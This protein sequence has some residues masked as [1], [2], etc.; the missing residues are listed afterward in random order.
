M[1]LRKDESSRRRIDWRY[2]GLSGYQT[3][4]SPVL[5]L[6]GRGFMTVEFLL[7]DLSLGR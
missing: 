6:P 2:D 1:I 4:P 5:R 7:E 3:V